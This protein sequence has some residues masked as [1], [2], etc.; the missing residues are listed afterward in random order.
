MSSR[1]EVAGED[2]LRL[3]VLLSGC[4]AIRIDESRMIVLGLAKDREHSVMLNPGAATGERYL[5][6]VREVLSSHAIRSPGGYPVFL[7]RWTRMGQLDSDRLQDLLK[8]G[9][10]EA[11]I[12]VASSKGLTPRIARL[13]WWAHPVA[14]TARFLLEHDSIRSDGLGAELADFLVEYLPF[15]T[16]PAVI[17][18]TV[19]L[20]LATGET[21]VERV[22]SL[23][24]R[25]Q[26]KTSVLVG[27]VQSRPFDLPDSGAATASHDTTH[28]EPLA[29]VFAPSEL[30]AVTR[31]L[32]PAGYRFLTTCNRIL[33]RPADQ[34]MVVECLEALSRQLTQI[35]PDGPPC[36]DIGQI[37]ERVAATAH[38]RLLDE[39]ADEALGRAIRALWFLSLAEEPLVRGFFARSST[40]GSLMRRQ[41][42]PI[43]GPVIDR[44]RVAAEFARQEAG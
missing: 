29:R 1:V 37:E 15:E 20:V 30:A 16:E 10:P 36:D 34:D 44:L 6:A 28:V 4:D 22:Q 17:S 7:K 21:K 5:R 39:Q 13:A 38:S 23:W 9:E 12:A 32:S 19:R 43:L 31:L 8:L 25:G 18:S 11:V 26:R 41:L 27:F 33:D 24:Q 40:V 35:R 2:V 3:H 14:E 42:A